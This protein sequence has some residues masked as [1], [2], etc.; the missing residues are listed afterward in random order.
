MSSDAE[1]QAAID[2]LNGKD[3]QGRALTVN[4]A[5]PREDR[6]RSGGFGGGRSGGGRSGVVAAAA[7]A[8]AATN[9]YTCERAADD[10]A[11]LAYVLGC[12]SASLGP[13]VRMSAN[14]VSQRTLIDR[15]RQ[16][17]ATT[18]DVEAVLEKLAL[19]GQ[20]A[21]RGGWPSVNRPIRG[22]PGIATAGC[23][24]WITGARA[25]RTLGCAMMFFIPDGKYSL[26]VFSLDDPADGTIVA[27]CEDVLAAAVKA[28]L[29]TPQA[30][31]PHKHFVLGTPQAIQIEQLD[32]KTEN[33]PPHCNA[34]TGWNRRAI[35]ITM[36]ANVSAEQTDA[37]AVI[38][39]L[40]ARW[41]DTQAQV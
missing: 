12:E 15:A 1:A 16:L 22:A 8:A 35:K 33:V 40:S 24:V 23:N 10:A 17:A 7:A 36:P 3:F 31:Q 21:R 28:K 39:A 18:I 34:M 27:C 38:C 29:V 14:V 37:V 26:Q 19:R 20:S 32:G 13:G 41:Q 4:V 9:A 2:A 11:R 5:K 30:G 6:P 25:P